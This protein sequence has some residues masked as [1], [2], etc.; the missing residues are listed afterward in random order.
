MPN[1]KRLTEGEGGEGEGGEGGGKTILNCNTTKLLKKLDTTKLLKK[2][3]SK[4]LSRYI[5][6]HNPDYP[7]TV[8]VRPYL[9]NIHS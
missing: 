6:I 1:T 4:F 9:S 2:L 3:D 8:V 5:N 7:T